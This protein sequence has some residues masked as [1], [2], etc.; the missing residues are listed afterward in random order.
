MDDIRI[1]RILRALRRR[2]GL[3]QVD[4]ARLAGVSQSLISLIER[5]HLASVSVASLRQV[6]AVLDARYEGSISWRGGALD[7]LLDQ[8]HADLVERI[9]RHLRDRGWLVH[10]EVT[11]NE[12]GE[13]GSIDLLGLKPEL[14]IALVGEIKTEITAADDTARRLDVKVR[15]APKIVFDRFGWRPATVGR[16]LVVLDTSTNRRRIASLEASL[17]SAVPERGAR[18]R[19]WLGTPHGSVAGLLFLSPTNRRG[20]RTR[21]PRNTADSRPESGSAAT[22]VGT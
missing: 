2:L 12:F 8:A 3:R 7:R 21:R 17:G 5:G 22:P 13:R 18:L 9:A 19:R 10:V 6:F 14:G 11:F 4:V 16:L 1:G 20:T 15:L